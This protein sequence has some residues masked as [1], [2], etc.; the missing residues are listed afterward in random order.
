MLRCQS[1]RGV[2]CRKGYPYWGLGTYELVNGLWKLVGHGE[3]RRTNKVATHAP[4]EPYLPKIRHNQLVCG[5]HV[6]DIIEQVVRPE[7]LTSDVTVFLRIVFLGEMDKLPILR[8]AL[9]DA[10]CD[11][12]N[13]LKWCAATPY[14]GRSRARRRL[15]LMTG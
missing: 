15:A 1:I 8:D 11:D 14:T 4:T 3:W 2:G 9:M 12:E 7:H 10:G 5:G 6:T 13:V